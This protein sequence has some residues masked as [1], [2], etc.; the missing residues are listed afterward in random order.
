MLQTASETHAQRVGVEMAW[1]KLR[2]IWKA[3]HVLLNKSD[4]AM[5]FP[6]S[7]CQSGQ[8]KGRI[9]TDDCRVIVDEEAETKMTEEP[10]V[11]K[12]QLNREGEEEKKKASLLKEQEINRE[13]Q[14]FGYD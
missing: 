13:Q 7:K 4:L 5:G 8:V 1:S 9:F 3:H 2:E 6:G 14:F 11:T 10:L 12:G